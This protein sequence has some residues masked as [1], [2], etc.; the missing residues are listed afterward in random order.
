MG[1][2]TAK[3]SSKRFIAAHGAAV[4]AEA[5]R[6]FRAVARAQKRVQVTIGGLGDEPRQTIAEQQGIMRDAIGAELRL[7]PKVG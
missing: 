2:T 4:D 1:R 7:L 3:R 5:A 6:F